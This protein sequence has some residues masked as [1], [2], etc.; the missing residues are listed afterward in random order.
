MNLWGL[1]GIEETADKNEIRRAFARQS[2]KCHPEDDP[3]GFA[4]LRRAYK[5]AIKLAEYRDQE[6]YF[7]NGETVEAEEKAAREQLSEEEPPR[8]EPLDFSQ[9]EYIPPEPEEKEEAPGEEPPDFSQEESIP[10][11]READE[12]EPPEEIIGLYKTASKTEELTERG[13]A[14]LG[15]AERLLAKRP[16]MINRRRCRSFFTSSDFR[17]EKNSS[18]FI[19]KLAEL[20]KKAEIPLKTWDNAVSPAIEKLYAE[21][22]RSPDSRYAGASLEK[23]RCVKQDEYNKRK[24]REL[25]IWQKKNASKKGNSWRTKPIIVVIVLV[26]LAYAASIFEVFIRP[27]LGYDRNM[28][29]TQSAADREERRNREEQELSELLERW[30][31]EKEERAAESTDES[32]HES[33]EEDPSGLMQAPSEA[34][35]EV[36]VISVED[37][38]PLTE[39]QKWRIVSKQEACDNLYMGIVRG[40][41]F[42]EESGRADK[43]GIT[44]DKY[45][46]LMKDYEEDSD[47]DKLRQE[48]K[49]YCEDE[50]ELV[51]DKLLPEIYW[52]LVRGEFSLKA[53]RYAQIMDIRET[54]L[55]ELKELYQSGETEEARTRLLTHYY[56]PQWMSS[57]LHMELVE[58]ENGRVGMRIYTYEEETGSHKRIMG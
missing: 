12:Y 46:S 16:S 1:L 47:N 24:R 26:V 40:N 25:A 11:E 45:N 22:R 37:V 33:E 4:E 28:V 36:S 6:P 57:M 13:A 55:E 35:Y 3:E 54:E 51:S 41:D 52:G 53:L 38:L 30:D 15:E 39:S 17:W 19:L 20:I 2:K 56:L 32:S 48:L 9:Q 42:E 14:L 29:T 58:W 18:L 8:E 10:P 23:S 7:E 50:L 43:L 27:G 49:S 21:L 31:K 34:Q 44:E 5:L